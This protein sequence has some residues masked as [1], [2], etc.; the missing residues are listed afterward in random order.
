MS[1]ISENE[2][3]ISY[4]RAR[5]PGG[6][7]VNKVST[8]VQLRFDVAGSS[9]LTDDVK[10]RLIKL[11]GRRMTR[12]GH[13]VIEARRYR[14]QEKNRKDAIHRFQVLVEKAQ[15][16]PLPRRKTSPTKASR[17]R[18][19]KEKKQRGELKRVR[20]MKSTYDE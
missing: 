10:E 2:L 19:L 6:Q 16:Q 3:N 14:D 9:L 4:I 8:A 20:T 11:A 17:E 12:D 18:R 13:L 7:N 5:G 1:K 15:K